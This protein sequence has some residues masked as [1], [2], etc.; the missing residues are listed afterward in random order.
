MEI[1]HNKISELFKVPKRW[2]KPLKLYKHDLLVQE[3]DQH[4]FEEHTH[5]SQR[6]KG[7]YKMRE[8]VTISVNK[9][10]IT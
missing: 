3:N 1:T 4:E 9:D 5:T 10:S 2:R 7:L 8:N 6:Q